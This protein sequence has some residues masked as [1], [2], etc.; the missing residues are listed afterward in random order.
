V[1]I[2]NAYNIVKQ[3]GAKTK[4]ACRMAETAAA[5]AA[6]ALLLLCR[7]KLTCIASKM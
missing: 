2:Q 4:T 7:A 5:A 6:I 3:L 1:L